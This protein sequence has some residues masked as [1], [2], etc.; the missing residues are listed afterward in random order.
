MANDLGD[1]LNFDMINPDVTMPK[2]ELK[3]PMAP[4]AKFELAAVCLNW[5]SMYLGMNV[6]YPIRPNTKNELLAELNTSI[7]FV[8]I[9]FRDVLK[10]V[11]ICSVFSSSCFTLRAAALGSVLGKNIIIIEKAMHEI[12]MGV[13]PIHQAPIHL[14]SSLVMV[15]VR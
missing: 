10:S 14:G 13:Q 12:P 15:G 7:L 9:R 6:Q 8:K 2:P 11:E 5:V 1:G 3:M 4:D